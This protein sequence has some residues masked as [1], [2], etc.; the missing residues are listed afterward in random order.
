MNRSRLPTLALASTLALGLGGCQ[1]LTQLSQW[2]GAPFGRAHPVKVTAVAANAPKPSPNAPED[3]LYERAVT[4][5]DRRDY[6]LALDMLQFAREARPDDPR[7][8]TAMGVVYDKLARFDLSKRYYDLAEKADPGSK[9]VAI[10]RA[11][12]LVLQQNVGVAVKPTPAVELAQAP[13]PRLSS[14][15]VAPVHLAQAAPTK[16]GIGLPIRV[17][18]ATGKPGFAEPVR[19]RLADK[20]WRMAD[21]VEDARRAIPVTRLQFPPA[22]ERLASRLAGSLPFPVK[23]D[24]CASCRRVELVLGTDALPKHGR[25]AKDRNA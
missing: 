5:I 15:A 20:G 4:A 12:S 14:V 21:D 13:V 19:S 1:N 23:L 9:V 11:Y 6:A 17:R 22:A 3:A 18:N 25:S 2:M 10:D 24:S 8:L 16:T 7:V